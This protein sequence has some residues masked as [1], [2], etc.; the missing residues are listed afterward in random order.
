MTTAGQAKQTDAVPP[1]GTV[2]GVNWGG[3][4][5]EATI[6][7]DRGDLGVGGRRIVSVAVRDDDGDVRIFELPAE[8]LLPAPA[9]S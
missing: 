3:S 9:Q 2:V 5:V 7:E 1:P 4:V 8:E 6:V